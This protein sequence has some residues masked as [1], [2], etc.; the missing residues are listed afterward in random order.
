MYSNNIIVDKKGQEVC[1]VTILFFHAGPREELDGDTLLYIAP[2]SD[3]HSLYSQ[4]SKIK[5][6]RL[7]KHTIRYYYTQFVSQIFL[8]QASCAFN[9]SKTDLLGAGQFGTVHKGEWMTSE[10]GEKIEVA[11][12]TLK[13]GAGEGDKVKFLQEAAIMG[14]FSHPNVVKLFGVV[15][16]RKLVSN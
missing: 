8:L 1:L 13:E 16:E 9:N 14:Q 4:F 6:Q 11:V 5:I 2:A 15:I 3:E 12:K 10:G 7:N